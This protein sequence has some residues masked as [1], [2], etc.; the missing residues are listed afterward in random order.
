MT[1]VVVDA[2]VAAKWVVP[3]IIEPLAAQADRLLRAYAAGTV[4]ILV[5]DLFWLEI[6]NFLWKATRRR[7]IAVEVAQRSLEAMLSRGFPTV[8]TRS[9]LPDALK[10]AADFD[11]TV[12]DSAY[13]ALAVATQS[14]LITADERLA[15]ALAARFPVRWL[16][17]F[18]Q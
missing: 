18:H 8:P 1:T 6:G 14:E 12:Y 16:G 4:H 13:V 9:L 15:N 11:R 7:E 3:E 2:S 17:A 5:P 10:I